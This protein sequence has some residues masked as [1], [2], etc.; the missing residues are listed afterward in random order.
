MKIARALISVHDK[1]GV[2][3]LAAALVALDVEILST[4]GTGELL[5]ASGVPASQIH[6]ARVCTSCYRESFHSFRVDGDRAGRMIGVIRARY[7]P[8]AR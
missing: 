8:G 6:V 1:T 5:R 4:G 3:E 7:A 2:A